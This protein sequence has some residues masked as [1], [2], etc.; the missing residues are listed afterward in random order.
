[1]VFFR[2]TKNL[3]EPILQRCLYQ[4]AALSRAAQRLE[5]EEA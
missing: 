4:P 1:M 5:G 2:L 3:P